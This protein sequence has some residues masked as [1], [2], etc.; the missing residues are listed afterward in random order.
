[1]LW[2]EKLPKAKLLHRY[3][4][5]M[6][7]PTSKEVRITHNQR[8]KYENKQ[9]ARSRDQKTGTDPGTSG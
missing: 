4:H 2:E 3:A 1:M 9:I 8:D 7:A 5:G 6:L